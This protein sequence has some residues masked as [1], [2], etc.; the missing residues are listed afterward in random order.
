MSHKIPRIPTFTGLKGIDTRIQQLQTRLASQISWLQYSFGL[1]QP[2]LKQVGEDEIIIPV[3]H[4][5]NTTDAYDMRPW[6]DD[7]H[8]SYSFWDMIDMNPDYVENYSYRRYPALH[9]S[10]ACIII[11]NLD[12]IGS[13][14]KDNRSQVRQDILNF[15][16]NNI[17]L[18][19]M[20]EM[21]AMIERDIE[22][23]FDGYDIEDPLILLRDNTAAFRVEG[24]VTFK[25]DC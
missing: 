5:D 11:V 8:N 6:L 3:C 24:V 15:F 12:S 2:V 20:F 9:Y 25:Q 14:Y 13:D 19:G 10:V 1:C 22:L 21:T 16:H 4:V 23:I 18:Y 17:R 7:S